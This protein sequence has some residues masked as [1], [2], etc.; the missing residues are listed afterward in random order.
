MAT[1]RMKLLFD[2]NLS[3]HLTHRLRDLYPGSLHVTNPDLGLIDANDKTDDGE[4]WEYARR[5]TMSIATTDK[6]FCKRSRESGHPPKVIQMPGNCT[7]EET[8]RIL[9][10]RY[11]DLLAFGKNEQGVLDL[12]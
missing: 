9:R 1:F 6:G 5:H 3:H 7:K 4:I 11:G 8:E 10:E 12:T 2:Q